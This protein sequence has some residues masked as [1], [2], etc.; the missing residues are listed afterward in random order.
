MLHSAVAQ[1]L[2]N[3]S[4]CKKWTDIQFDSISFQQQGLDSNNTFQDKNQHNILFIINFALG[5]PP[6]QYNQVNDVKFLQLFLNERRVQSNKEQSK[7]VKVSEWKD[8]S[9]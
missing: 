7:C 5:Q 8:R 6:K 9:M 4:L 2:A 3:D 1:Y